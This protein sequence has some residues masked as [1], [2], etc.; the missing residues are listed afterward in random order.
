MQCA[1]ATRN[2]TESSCPGILFAQIQ[3]LR[4]RL[5]ASIE[6]ATRKFGCPE[7]ARSGSEGLM[8]GEAEA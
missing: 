7:L 6:G 8:Q 3:K 4:G 5:V 1:E 2:P